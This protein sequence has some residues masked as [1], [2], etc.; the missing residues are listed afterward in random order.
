M[1]SRRFFRD[2]LI[3]SNDLT[4]YELSENQG[5]PVSTVELRSNSGDFVST[6]GFVEYFNSSKVRLKHVPKSTKLECKARFFD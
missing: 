5:S 6:T 1:P 2:V 3:D 4:V